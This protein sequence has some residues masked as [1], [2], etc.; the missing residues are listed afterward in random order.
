MGVFAHF[1]GRAYGKLCDEGI[2]N[3]PAPPYNEH[4]L[5]QESGFCLILGTDIRSVM[6]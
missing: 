1:V 6:G 3:M 4:S 2:L 5:L